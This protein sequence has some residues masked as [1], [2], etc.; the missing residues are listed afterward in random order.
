MLWKEKEFL[1]A[2][3]QRKNSYRRERGTSWKIHY[4]DSL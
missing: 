4:I 2:E 3:R 1:E